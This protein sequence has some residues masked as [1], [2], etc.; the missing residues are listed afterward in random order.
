MGVC[1]CACVCMYMYVS[2]FI[3]HSLCLHMSR[4]GSYHLIGKASCSLREI[5]KDRYLKQ[6]L[7]YILL[8]IKHWIY[9]YSRTL[10]IRTPMCHFNVEGVQINEF[11][12]ISELSDKIHYLASQLY[13]IL[14]LHITSN[15]LRGRPIIFYILVCFSIHCATASQLYVIL[16]LHITSNEL[17][18]RPILFY[19]LVCFSIHCATM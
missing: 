17:R 10:I 6:F 5:A 12:R 18:G 14:F 4:S 13:V 16:F 7:N 15:E 11:V 9:I 2:A 1:M 8:C 3:T 19:I